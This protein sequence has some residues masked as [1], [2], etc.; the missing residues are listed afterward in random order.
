[1]NGPAS[2]QPRVVGVRFEH[3]REALGLGVER[4]RLSWTI[5]ADQPGW[6]Q[7]AYEVQAWAPG[8]QLIAE[9]G[10][11]ESE[12]SV[13]IPWP[14]APLHSRDRL[15][16]R[17]RVWGVDGVATDWSDRYPLEAGLLDAADWSARFVSPGWDE[18]TTRP[19]PGP[20]LR[21]E[22]RVRPGVVQARLYVTSLGVFEALINGMAVGDH[23]M[24]P[25]WTSYDRRLRYQTFDVAGLLQQGAN[26]TGAML[27]DGWYRSRLGWN[28]GRRNCYGDRLGLLAQL[29]ITY[30]DGTVQRVVTDETWRSARGPILFSDIYDGETY[31]ARNERPGWCTA[32]YDDRDWSGVFVLERDLRSLVAPDGPPVRCIETLSPVAILTS[33]SGKMIADFGQNIVGRVRLNVSGEAGRAITIRHAEVLEN[34]ELCTRPLRTAKA[35]DCYILKGEGQE[36]WEPRFTFHGFRYAEIDGWPGTLPAANVC[37][38]VCHSDLERTGWFECS[39]PLYNR[40]H[41]NT[42]WS[43]RGNFFDVPT[44]CPQRDERLGW[45]GDIQLFS[46]TACFLYDSAGFLAS[47]LAD[48]AADQGT[49]G[50]VPFVVPNT[51][52][53]PPVGAAGW[54]DAAA[55]V[56]WTLYE[57]YGD[58]GV[59]ARQY[60]SMA[61]WVDLLAR[62]S[63]DARLW[64]RGFQFGDWLDPAAP[65]DDAA[66][67][68]T[69]PYLA[70][71]AYFARSA[72][73][74]ARAAAVLGRDS[75]AARYQALA[76]EVREAFAR[77]FVTPAGRLTSDTATAYA[78][79]IQFDL[80]PHAE[81]RVRAGDRLAELVRSN[82][83]RISTGLLGTPAICD[84]LCAAGQVEAALRLFD[85]RRCPS[86]LYPVTMGATTIWERWDSLRPDGSV[87]PGAM[88]SFNHYAL[89][90]VADWL[91]RTVGGLAPAE[92]GYR[93][94][95]IEPRPGR[96]LTYADVR[97][98]TPYGMASCK[99][100]IEGECIAVEVVV[101]PNTTATVRLPGRGPEALEAGSGVHHWA[102]PYRRQDELPAPSPDSTLD[103]LYADPPSWNAVLACLLT[104]APD[105]MGR[106][107]TTQRADGGVSLRQIV[108]SA[109]RPGES[110]AALLHQL[111]G[112]LE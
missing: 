96:N 7:A 95:L 77:Q 41:A 26:A 90:S 48:L 65:P 24:D 22:F 19:Q 75:D 18:D 71:T 106:V 52:M 78:L 59:L 37:A 46:P 84:A 35:T 23:V 91:Y 79:A 50:A 111:K 55:V 102:Y 34:G 5:E 28:G 101:P 100:R 38:V 67:A 11:T 21:K 15:E 14:F 10:R 76:C 20:L 66:A 86:W 98:R 29:E 57:R 92:P 70:A 6:Q 63:G 61:A 25:G 27:G 104:H 3:R 80:L 108:S 4:P 1:M 97:H 69:D 53:D 13:L 33:R 42:V 72:A 109:A 89:G 60:G 112:L 110:E 36:T 64:D 16:V 43:M 32:G 93:R 17:V 9:T 40:F 88:T 2:T 94:L 82:G 39:E 56:P 74:V 87:N 103:D 44:D 99:W 31:D 107:V 8:G 73:I 45:T 83:Y 81:Q 85:E 62:L 49:D 58:K 30:A 68:R 47:W 12:D 105:L 51:L 54:G